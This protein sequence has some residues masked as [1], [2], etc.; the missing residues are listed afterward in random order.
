[1]PELVTLGEPMVLLLAEG[2]GPLREATSFRRFIAGAESNVAIGVVRLGRTAGIVT[3]LGDDEFGRAILFRLRGEGVDTTQVRIDPQ[4]RT[5]VYFR[6]AR[7]SGRVEV[8]YY[9]HGSAASRISPDDLSPEYVTGARVVHL[10]GI[11]PALSPS[12]R[13]ATFAAA[14]MARSAKV[15]VTLDPN[16]R[17]RL[18]PADEARRVLRDLAGRADVVL[19][20][21][22]EAELLTGETEPEAA[23]KALAALGPST[24]VIRLAGRG[25][26]TLAEGQIA[27]VKPS[28]PAVALD[29]VGAG[30][31][32]A[33]GFHAAR[34][35]GRAL[36]TATVVGLRCA[37]IAVASLGDCE[38]LPSW[39]DLQPS[40]ADVRR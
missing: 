14:E 8:L 20:G 30:D 25:A 24:V 32:F 36:A 13:E 26:L 23:A 4:A 27:Q 38:A 19:A 37:A 22:D 7:G 17:L 1:M 16:V 29:P 2:S 39:D 11:T 31:A 5:G 21:A 3:R 12:C 33:A 34:L 6:D 28:A 15:E 18:W 40:G 10:T 9:R 35:R